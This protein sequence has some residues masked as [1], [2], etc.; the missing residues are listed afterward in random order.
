MNFNFIFLFLFLVLISGLSMQYA[1]ALEIPHYFEQNAVCATTNSTAIALNVTDSTDFD[2]ISGRDYL[3]ISTASFGGD[4]SSATVDIF[5]AHNETKFDGG[6]KIIEPSNGL[7]AEC[8]TPNDDINKYFFWTLWSPIGSEANEDIVIG[9]NSTNSP[10]FVQYD[11]VTMTIIELS[12]QLTQDVDWFHNSNTT[13]NIIKFNSTAF[14]STNNAIIQFTP[15]ENNEDWLI[16][17]TN[18]I[19]TASA[20]VS[21]LTRLF[22]NGTETDLPE[23]HQEGEDPTA[24]KFVQT[25]ARVLTLPNSTQVIEVQ[26]NLDADI[27]GIHTREF[28]AVFALNL[29]KFVDHSF[30]WS[31]AVL[32]VTHVGSFGT[33]VDSISIT[34]SSNNTDTFILADIGTRETEEQINLRLQVD[35]V[36]DPTGQTAQEY[37]FLDEWDID[38]DLRWTVGIIQN[39]TNSSH[40]IDVDGG[41]T[42][43][44]GAKAV[45]RTLVAFSMTLRDVIV[46]Q[47][48]SFSIIDANNFTAIITHNQ[49]DNM[50]LNDTNNF[51]AILIH[52]QTDN[53]ILNDT[54]NIVAIL[55]H[56]QTDNIIFNDTND[57]SAILNLTQTDDMNLND[58]NDFV[59]I[60]TH[61]QTDNMILNDTNNIVAN[62][63]HNQIDSMILNDT[64]DFSAILNLTQTDDL[65]LNDTND[66]SAILNLTQT[67]DMN[68]NDTNDFVGIFNFT[69]SDNISFPDANT[70]SFVI[71]DTIIDA[72]NFID[73]NSFA[74][75]TPPIV[76][77]PSGGG[78]AGSPPPTLPDSDFDG[79]P[80]I[81]DQCPLLPEDFDGFE[82]ADGCPEGETITPP[83]ELLAESLADLI[84]FEFN[85]LDVIDDFIV[86]ETDQP[87]PQVEDLGVRWLGA[88]PITITSIDIGQSP[89]EIQI[90]DIPIEFGNNQFGYTETQ[91]LYTVQEPDEVCG[92]IFTFNC[93]D[94]VTYKIPIVVSGEINGKTVIA[95][96]SITIDNSGRANPFS[97]MLWVLLI[98]PLIAFLIWK[99]HKGRIVP[100]STLLKVT[101]SKSGSVVSVRSEKPLKAG[102]TRSKL[103]EKSTFRITRSKESLKSEPQK[104]K[105]IKEKGKRRNI[106]GR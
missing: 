7:G 77:P 8:I 12:E 63:I 60:I 78:T 54:N 98:I 14:N 69:Q 57:F 41:E 11:D 90:Q 18:T 95:E 64:N 85:E 94:T 97:F 96:G 56:N 29:D 91:I 102:T 58:T 66:F 21:Y 31:P 49:T 72:F 73:V 25:F 28:S 27:A 48:D 47:I 1:N 38:D 61:N 44:S 16:F 52:N 82:D 83:E 15:E 106:L 23:I 99:R 33:L 70:F 34:P 55:T 43:N 104:F 20:V 71:I 35:N 86:L 2:F 68:L 42:T 87:Q 13:D 30:V 81:D 46:T 80:D 26:A 22:V 93:L 67:D 17:G 51:V 84:P 39:L 75:F 36:D 19:D 105:S 100:T 40:T 10:S 62:L 50:I 53:M 101:Q 89:F 45:Y 74:F 103:N 59:N 76:I 24:E 5:T 9:V 32:D 79:I 92:N 3:I 88:E 6:L 4:L 37:E 65:N